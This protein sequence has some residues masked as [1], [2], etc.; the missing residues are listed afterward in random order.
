MCKEIQVEPDVR[1]LFDWSEYLAAA[2]A[3]VRFDTIFYLVA[4]PELYPCVIAAD[5]NE[6]V[7]ANVGAPLP[8]L[9]SPQLGFLF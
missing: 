4:L 8:E 7:S 9:V 6:T 5:D 3:K 1:S 2:V